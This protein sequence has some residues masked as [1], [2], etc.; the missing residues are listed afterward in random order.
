MK[1]RREYVLE[2]KNRDREGFEEIIAR[3]TRLR[4]GTDFLERLF[5]DTLNPLRRRKVK[6]AKTKH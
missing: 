1:T 5:E 4:K 6:E 2:Y 3:L